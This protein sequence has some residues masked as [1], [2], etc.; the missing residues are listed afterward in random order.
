MS[1]P[2]AV[3]RRLTV[4]LA[5]TAAGAAWSS[6][7]AGST[8]YVN[9]TCGS[10][11]WAGTSPVCA[12]PDGPKRH[13]QAGINQA[14]NGDEVVVADGVYTGA[15]NRDL[16]FGGTLIRVRSAN[17]PDACVID[18]QGNG[19]AFY[20]RSEETLVAVIQG[21]TI[22]NG[23][24]ED[25]G[26][27]LLD[28]ADATISDCVFTNN[29]AET[30]GAIFQVD[31][32][33]SRYLFLADCTFSGNTSYVG[34]G[35]VLSVTGETIGLGTLLATG[36]VFTGNDGGLGPG[37]VGSVQLQAA[38]IN[39]FFAGNVSDFIAGGLG[40]GS[41]QTTLINCVF[42]R[43]E[44]GM[45]G[46]ATVGGAG[47]HFINCTVAGN[48]GG[49]VL[50]GQSDQ[51]IALTNCVLWGNSP[52]Q[53]WVDFTEAMATFSDVQGGW[54]GTG[55]IDADPLFVDPGT[56]NVRL[57]YGSPCVN[58][59][60]NGA[61]P[62][63]TT[64]D[65]DGN[66]RILDGIVDMG[67]YEGEFEPVLPTAEETDLDCGEQV[68]LVPTGGPLDPVQ[69]AAVIVE[70]TSGPDDALFLVTE[71]GG[72]VHP[73]AGGYSELS[74]VLATDTTL[75]D[76]QYLA[77]QFIP[78]DA[79]D[80]GGI[81]PL[82][83]DLTRYDPSAGTWALAAS[84]NTTASPGFDGPL[85]DRIA[86]MDGGDWGVTTDPGDYGVYWDPAAQ[87]GFAWANVG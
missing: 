26:A 10:D 86:S 59:G 13:I 81:D 68:V 8:W 58:A 54:P 32:H 82:H 37:A 19:R 39:C 15:G 63:G 55:N 34:G 62:P 74:C 28:R 14:A 46:G 5:V 75:A 71:N 64:A 43:N 33:R 72:D 24:A 2:Q 48:L 21:F 16:D 11:A 67:A 51:P 23:S 12:A 52:W 29:T 18:C 80:L 27:I 78:F 30:G 3:L 45:G 35:A 1:T 70:N 40:E 53:I 57:S 42:S 22:T 36:C 77:T 79:D 50:R 87:Q 65:I 60:D 7:A 76:G 17:G 9:G 25:G 20:L 31:Y 69:S 38:Y 56:D 84:G 49:G 44:S 41:E 73:D 83:V 4:A 47:A 61:L 85:G 6:A 66:P